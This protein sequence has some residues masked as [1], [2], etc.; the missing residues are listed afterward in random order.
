[1]IFSPLPLP[2]SDL[3]TPAAPFPLSVNYTEAAVGVAGVVRACV[4]VRAHACHMRSVCLCSRRHRRGRV[5]EQ[6]GYASQR[7]LES[8]RTHN[9][10]SRAHTFSHT[11][12]HKSLLSVPLALCG[13][14]PQES[15]C[16]LHGSVLCSISPKRRTRT[17]THTNMHT[18]LCSSPDERPSISPS[19]AVR[20]RGE[21]GSQ[22]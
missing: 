8:V 4:R 14:C 7:C 20:Q 10:E 2:A 15:S 19:P 12:T 18:Q 6:S 13:L 16:C 1:M 3:P 11:D 9:S 21:V 5:T 22:L 17:Q